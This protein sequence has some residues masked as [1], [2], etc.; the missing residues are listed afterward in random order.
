MKILVS[1]LD[2]TLYPHKD[3]VDKH[4]LKKNIA[5]IKRWIDRGNKLA[6]ATARGFYHYEILKDI[7][8]FDVN[9]IGS[10][11]ASL[12]YEDGSEIVKSMPNSIYIDLCRFVKENNIN[13]TVATGINDEWVWSSIDCYPKDH[14]SYT[15]YLDTVTIA[16]LDIIDPN[17]SNDRIQVFSPP[18]NINQ[19]RELIGSQ[20]YQ[21]TI[22]S[23]DIDMLDLVPLDCSKGISIMEMSKKFNVNID[24]IIVVG[25]SENDIPMFNVTKN[26]YCISHAKDFVRNSASAVVSSVEELINIELN[27]IDS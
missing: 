7:L 8:G 5:A 23:S 27:K 13:A 4:Q 17:S 10:N 15:K 14:P 19:L 1:D 20:N 2:G 11:G 3:Y 16:D 22:T 24:D 9:F 6:V 21:T 26:S 25:D 18:D 12:R